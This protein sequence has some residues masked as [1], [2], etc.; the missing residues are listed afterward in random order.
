MRRSRRNHLV[1]EAV[2]R[3][4][5]DGDQHELHYLEAP[6]V[7]LDALPDRYDLAGGAAGDGVE[8]A[9]AAKA[10][11]AAGDLRGIH[12]WDTFPP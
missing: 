9:C 6:V 2:Q 5:K 11:Y 12:S 10:A 7:R 3:G 8:T 4:A 1:D